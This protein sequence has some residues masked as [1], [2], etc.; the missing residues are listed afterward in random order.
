M[1]IH[2]NIVGIIWGI[3]KDLIPDY[4]CFLMTKLPNMSVKSS[5]EI[6][7]G[8][9][10]LGLLSY[11]IVSKNFINWSLTFTQVLSGLWIYKQMFYIY[12]TI[13]VYAIFLRMQSGLSKL[14]TNYITRW[15]PK[16]NNASPNLWN[17]NDIIKRRIIFTIKKVLVNHLFCIIEAMRLTDN[18]KPTYHSHIITMKKYNFNTP[19][20]HGSTDSNPAN[21][22]QYSVMDNT[23]YKLNLWFKLTLY[24]SGLC[25]ICH[26]F[27]L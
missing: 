16:N 5:G 20:K 18:I 12:A 14:I 6:K 9:I 17:V 19:I 3:K 27:I 2:E 25:Q 11:I 7:Y 4:S 22:K 13:F 8:I 23:G 1:N 26:Q 24:T 21:I 10:T 15:S